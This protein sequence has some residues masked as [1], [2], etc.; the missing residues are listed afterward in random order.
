MCISAFDLQNTKGLR[1][2]FIRVNPPPMDASF[3]FDDADA[4]L[5]NPTGILA[6]PHDTED[7]T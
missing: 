7:A 3:S 2:R 6:P 1:E 4:F 5:G